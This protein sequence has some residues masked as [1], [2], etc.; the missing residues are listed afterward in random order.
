MTKDNI[1]IL[2]AVTANTAETEVSTGKAKS[3]CIT[4]VA[5]DTPTATVTVYGR[6]T[7]SGSSIQL[8]TQAYTGTA[9][10]N[11]LYFRY[12]DVYP[13]ITAAVTGYSAGTIT[14]TM[15]LGAE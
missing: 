9:G 1:T 3:V 8:G 11:E 14:V 13:Y 2:S 5:A 10:N 12:G 6:T 7:T 4:C 15:T